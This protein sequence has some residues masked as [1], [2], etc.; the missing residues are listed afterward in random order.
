MARCPTRVGARVEHEAA[1]E[2][3]CRV[4]RVQPCDCV[5]VGAVRRGAQRHRDVRVAALAGRA[6]KASPTN[7]KHARL[8]SGKVSA[9]AC[10]GAGAGADADA[11]AGAAVVA[12]ADVGVGAG[13]AVD[14]GDCD[15]EGARARVHGCDHGDVGPF[16]SF[17][18]VVEAA[19]VGP[20]EGEEDDDC[21]RVGVGASENEGEG[22]DSHG[23]VHTTV[24]HA[25]DVHLDQ[26]AMALVPK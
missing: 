2:R 6:G 25:G 3:G 9:D 10:A 18:V 7:G 26:D 21:V 22:T 19:L 17:E 15:C 1:P 16:L 13:A 11:D 20:P 4:S 23:G 8:T 12:D 14:V 5:A 24:V